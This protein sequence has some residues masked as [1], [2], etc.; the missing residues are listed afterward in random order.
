MKN[1]VVKTIAKIQDLANTILAENNKQK[2][3]ELL[4]EKFEATF[5]KATKQDKLDVYAHFAGIEFPIDMTPSKSELV[6]AIIESVLKDIEDQKIAE[7]D[8]EDQANADLEEN[9]ENS[10]KIEISIATEEQTP[11]KAIKEKIW[12]ADRIATEIENSKNVALSTL[13]MEKFIIV[14][15]VDGFAVRL[16]QETNRPKNLFTIHEV[17]H[18]SKQNGLELPA[19][20]RLAFNA[21][22]NADAENSFPNSDT[23]KKLKD[24]CKSVVT[25]K[26]EFRF[27]N[28]GMPIVKE[29]ALTNLQAILKVLSTEF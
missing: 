5:K 21:W 22:R 15:I 18:S 17:K 27:I 23:M 29:I 28:G 12:F 7:Q 13:D 2:A 24:L 8:I 9:N 1:T 26:N 16:N 25:N 14:P 3:I 4:E 11:K 19:M 20:F 6:I 10:V